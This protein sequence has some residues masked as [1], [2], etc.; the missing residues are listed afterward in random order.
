MVTSH[1]A[2]RGEDE[3]AV[4]RQRCRQAGLKLTPQRLA[5]YRVLMA[6]KEHPS[7][8]MVC[9]R[10]RKEMPSISLD[11][12]N[13]TLLTLTKIGIAFVVEGTGQVRR[14]D[15][16]LNDHQHF[17]CVRCKRVIDFHCDQFDNMVVPEEV[18]STFRILRTTVYVEGIC[19][20][21]QSEI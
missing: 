1:F 13:R 2:E 17:R 15:G 8:E 14:F 18:S 7:A 4:F 16:N 5:V 19:K 9:Q 6:S 21:C 12:V 20:N 3:I 10:I 11:T